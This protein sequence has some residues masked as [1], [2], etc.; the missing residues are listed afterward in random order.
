MNPLESFVALFRDTNMLTVCLWVC[1]AIL[2]CVE[3]FQPMH[4]AAYL[5]GGALLGAAFVSR[6]I[7]GDAGVAFFFI[8]LT[9]VMLF[10]VHALSLFTQKRDWLRA[11]RIEK[12]D[13]R[14]RRLNSLVGS[15]GTAVTPID[16]AGNVRI[17]DI[18]LAVCSEKPI[19]AGETVRIVGV[20]GDK[21]MVETVTVE[22]RAQA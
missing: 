13:R 19:A 9:A 15:V 18:N 4:G 22:E 3:F 2:F 6:V 12:A 14:S 1:G 8:L 11:A 7:Y 20:S 17:D 16:L 10:A 5:F 21:I